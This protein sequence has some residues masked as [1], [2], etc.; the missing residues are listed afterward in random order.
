[1]P[2]F[3]KCILMLWV[4]TFVGFIFIRIWAANPDHISKIVA[5]KYPTWIATVG[6][7]GILSILSIIPL[8]VY[9]LFFR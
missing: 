5:R 4:V 6:C 2:I 1:M 3:I 8:V 9:L 7:L